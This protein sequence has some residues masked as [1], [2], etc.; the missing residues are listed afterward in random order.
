MKFKKY[1]EKKLSDEETLIFFQVRSAKII[2][3]FA[4]LFF[5]TNI[6]LL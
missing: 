4:A 2:F 5:F 3:L 6:F 1:S